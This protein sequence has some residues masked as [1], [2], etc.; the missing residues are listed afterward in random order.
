[1]NSSILFRLLVVP[2]C[3]AASAASGVEFQKLTLTEEFVAEGADFADFN[4]DGHNDICAGPYYWLGPDFKERREF[5]QPAAEPYNAAKSYSDYFL[6][7]TYD[8]NGDGWADILVYS[9]PGKEAAW[10][11]NPQNKEGHWTKHVALAIADNES[12][13]VGDITGD[14]K[15]ELI[16]QSSGDS[17]KKVDG[18]VGYAEM[19]WSNPTA[20]ATF[21]G[22]TPLTPENNEKYFRYTHGYGFGDVN[23]DGRPDLLVKDAWF[24]QP[25][26]PTADG[27]WKEHKVDFAPTEDKGGA[28]ML[29]YDVNG[30]GRN[31]VITS[32]YAHGFGLS[33]SEQNADGSFTRHP[34]MGSTEKD[35][36]H[37]V[38]F[39]QIHALAL[40]DVNGDGVMD[41]VTGK[42][43]WAHGPFKD[44]EPNAAPV[45][46]WFELKRGESGA[47]DYVP[48]RIDDNSGVGVEVTPGDINGDG[49]VDVAV[50]NKKGVFVFLQK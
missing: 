5:N 21:H 16:C 4:H 31:D 3:L 38:K 7:Y 44:E 12:P 23:G 42:R 15:P 22:V 27:F 9:W 37:G 46:Y 30:D 29:V 8:F 47:V 45:L 26:E 6:T 36:P 25:A 10:Y 39:S 11:E 28:Q 50:S 32:H 20:P 24:E 18:Q 43:R 14:G 1:M 48:H 17:T 35:S 34:L 19:D 33:W 41:F 13:M 40:A 49:K 2:T